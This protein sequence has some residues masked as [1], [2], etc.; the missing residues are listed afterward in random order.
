MI[1][2]GLGAERQFLGDLGVAL[3]MSDHAQYLAFAVGQFR[4]EMC[5]WHR[6]RICEKL[7][8]TT[9]NGRTE[10]RLSMRDGVNRTQHL[11]FVRAFEQIAMRPGAHRGEDGVVIFQHSER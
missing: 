7:N 6:T 1:A 10:D 11:R 4:K 2:D 3:T 9:G 5:W 8:E